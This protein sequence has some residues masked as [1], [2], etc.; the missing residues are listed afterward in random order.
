MKIIKTASGK[1]KIKI[2]KKEWQS[3]G[4]KA[5][6]MD[7]EADYGDRFDKGLTYKAVI[8]SPD[9]VNEFERSDLGQGM[10]RYP[11][12]AKTAVQDN[13]GQ[14]EGAHGY[15]IDTSNDKIQALT[16]IKK[17]SKDSDDFWEEGD[18]YKEWVENEWKRYYDLEE[19][20]D[21]LNAQHQAVV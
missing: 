7:K 19:Y 8:E 21:A 18:P 13:I 17:N 16:V 14:F 20:K 6:W 1:S 3:I 2:S 9:G 4:K 11:E 5:G 15:I 12:E 10:F